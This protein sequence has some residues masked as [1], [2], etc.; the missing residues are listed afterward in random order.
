M[1]AIRP[2]LRIWVASQPVDF[3]S[4]IDRLV[5]LVAAMLQ[6][7]P[8]RGDLYVFRS[9]R[10]DRVKILLWDGTGL[11]LYHKRLEQGRFV[12]PPI[13]EGA[14]GLSSA[15]LAM[16]LDGLDW[17]QVTPASVQRPLRAA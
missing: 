17:T 7:D 16:L 6:A 3:R 14:V 1:I 15:Q 10:A 8:F 11:V 9:K 2:E 12:W 13:R 5:A 4:G